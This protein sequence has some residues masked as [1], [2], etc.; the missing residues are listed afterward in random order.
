M[1][2]YFNFVRFRSKTCYYAILPRSSCNVGHYGD[3]LAKTIKDMVMVSQVATWAKEIERY[4]RHAFKKRGFKSTVTH[5]VLSSYRVADLELEEDNGDEMLEY[6]D[7]AEP[8]DVPGKVIDED[9][10]DMLTE[11]LTRSQKMR[12]NELL[13]RWEEPE[14]VSEEEVCVCDD[15]CFKSAHMY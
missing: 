11:S 1:S 10:V 15:S 12:I 3:E 6:V 14:S 8:T 2:I 9:K 4:G 13:G 7:L 5:D